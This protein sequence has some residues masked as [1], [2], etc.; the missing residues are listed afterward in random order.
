MTF[1][2]LLRLDNTVDE[3]SF[4]TPGTAVI[5]YRAVSAGECD[6]CHSPTFKNQIIY[7]IHPDYVI[8]GCHIPGDYEPEVAAVGCSLGCGKQLALKGLYL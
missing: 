1:A 3:A 2:Q 6:Q 8:D 7:G 5:A 4:T